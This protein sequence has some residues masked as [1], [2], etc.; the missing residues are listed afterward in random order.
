MSD[1]DVH[2]QREECEK[3]KDEKIQYELKHEKHRH[4]TQ[5]SCTLPPTVSREDGP[6]LEWSGNAI[7]LLDYKSHLAQLKAVTWT[8]LSQW[9]G[10]TALKGT[11]YNR[12]HSF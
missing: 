3:F 8:F 4:Y 9:L 6:S 2:G 7:P 12:T 5:T 11:N 10:V 1:S